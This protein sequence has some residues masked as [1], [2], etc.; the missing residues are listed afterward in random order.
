MEI[1]L[2]E[3]G[4]PYRSRSAGG[5]NFAT[6]ALYAVDAVSHEVDVIVG[7]AV[8]SKGRRI[9]LPTRVTG[10]WR[11]LPLADPTVWEKA[12]RIIGQTSK[13]DLLTSRLV[14]TESSL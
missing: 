3:A 13:A 14:R 8:R 7:F 11:G 12:Y 6:T 10:S 5:E 1:A 2:A 4:Y 9:E